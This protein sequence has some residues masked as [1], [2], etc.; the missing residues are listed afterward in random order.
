MN[1]IDVASEPEL[2]MAEFVNQHR[3]CQMRVFRFW[4]V[5]LHENLNAFIGEDGGAR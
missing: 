5:G 3:A 4:D 1:I 2:Y